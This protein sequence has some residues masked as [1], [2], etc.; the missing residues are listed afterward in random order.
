MI[1]VYKRS[2]YMQNR[3]F[4]KSLTI[5]GLV[6]ALVIA[7][8]GC[9]KKLTSDTTVTEASA[10]ETIDPMSFTFID[11]KIRDY[12]F[13]INE[14]MREHLS[15]AT[16]KKTE[17]KTNNGIPVNSTYTISPDSKYESLQ[18]EKRLSNGVQVDEY[19]NMGDSVFVARTTIYDDGDYEPVEKY[20]I[21]DGG[22]YK[23]DGL[24][25]TVTKLA[26]SNDESWASKKM[27]L[28]LY[29]SFDEIRAIYG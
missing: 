10:Q 20:Y 6:T 8:T 7:G 29:F 9:S 2:T 3:G 18:M 17:G 26:D 13:S 15:E 16:Q 11:A 25:E 1:T 23:V 12:T 5:L 27:E 22:L 14:Y 21:F 28:D 4:I 24:A 19:F